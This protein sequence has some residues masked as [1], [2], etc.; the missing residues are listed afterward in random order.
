MYHL[1]V[2]PLRSPTG[3]SQDW[4]QSVIKTV[5]LSGDWRA[6]SI[7]LP[8]PASRGL[9]HSLACGL[10]P[11]S[12]RPATLQERI[13]L[14]CVLQSHLPLSTTRKASLSLS[15]SSITSDSLEQSRIP[16]HLKIFNLNYICNILFFLQNEVPNFSLTPFFLSHSHGFS[17][18]FYTL[19]W[20]YSINL[21]ADSSE[22]SLPTSANPVHQFHTEHLKAFLKNKTQLCRF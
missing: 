9:F 11:P 20:D 15:L 1:T 21:I 10:L 3:V 17:L 5:V 12:S 13:C 7:S 18:G 8:S 19:T 4:S 6:Q 22:E 14:S 16:S 2:P